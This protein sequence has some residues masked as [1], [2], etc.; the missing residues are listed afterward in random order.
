MAKKQNRAKPQQCT[1][2]RKSRMSS[3]KA[4]AARK[5]PAKHES[6]E[7][8][9]SEKAADAQELSE[10]VVEKWVLLVLRRL[11]EDFLRVTAGDG[12][13]PRF[14]SEQLAD[15]RVGSHQYNDHTSEVGLSFTCEVRPNRGPEP[16][17]NVTE[18]S[19]AGHERRDNA[20]AGNVALALPTVGGTEALNDR[21][22]TRNDEAAKTL[23]AKI[24]SISAAARATY[25][26]L[27]YLLQLG[28]REA[29][30]GKTVT[31]TSLPGENQKTKRDRIWWLKNEGAVVSQ[32][33]N[34]L[35][36]VSLTPLGK[37]A[38]DIYRPIITVEP[39]SPER[40]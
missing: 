32:S 34:R 38:L 8:R 17:T 6:D 35:E 12:R 26:S 11:L 25:T 29:F 40:S 21:D 16:T 20:G 3:G 5:T 22:S 4:K 33:K 10:A 37:R 9:A 2:T 1:D 18:R 13:S 15:S 31:L 39:T 27:F 14:V 19:A 30:D 7:T 23:L 28:D 24:T 36:R